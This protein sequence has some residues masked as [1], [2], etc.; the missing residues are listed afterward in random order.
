MLAY[1]TGI[2]LFALAILISV[3][4]H[5]FGHMLT[6]KA[7]KMKVTDEILAS[8]V[9]LAGQTGVAE[10]YAAIVH[11]W[12]CWAAPVHDPVTGAKL[13]VIDLSTTWDRTHP[14]G[15]ATARVMARLIEGALPADRRTTHVGAAGPSDPGLTLTLLGTA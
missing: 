8:L 11:N 2:I 1:T 4:L 5:E 10:H 6:A 14:I 7:F 3:S 9:R 13:G 12:V 15:L